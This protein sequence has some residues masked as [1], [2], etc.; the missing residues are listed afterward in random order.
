DQR[1]VERFDLGAAHADFVSP[2]P[3]FQESISE[4]S[5]EEHDGVT[6][7]GDASDRHQYRANA[8]PWGGAVGC[9]GRSGSCLGSRHLVPPLIAACVIA[10]KSNA[11]PCFARASAVSAGQ[12]TSR[13]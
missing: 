1:W 9:D 10:E 7:E 13:T 11:T 4:V 3:K 8:Q 5:D 2:D 6:D 12:A